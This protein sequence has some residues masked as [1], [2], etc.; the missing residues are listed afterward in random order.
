MQKP[1]ILKKVDHTYLTFTLSVLFTSLLYFH[2]FFPIFFISP[3]I[4][5]PYA[6][7]TLIITLAQWSIFSLFFINSCYFPSSFSSITYYKVLFT[8]D[9]KLS[10]KNLPTKISRIGIFKN[11]VFFWY[12]RIFSHSYS[13]TW[14]FFQF[15]THFDTVQF[16]L[17][18]HLWA[19][20]STTTFSVF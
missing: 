8:S 7:Y 18:Q 20:N 4:F 1:S 10:D 17:Y 13:Q 5:S 11:E 16:R 9:Q 3:L 14:H 2:H 15:Q 19:H 6:L 12:Y